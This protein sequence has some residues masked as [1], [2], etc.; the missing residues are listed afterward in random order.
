MRRKNIRA[1]LVT[2]EGDDSGEDKIA[3]LLHPATAESRVA[4]LTALLYANTHGTF[5]ERIACAV[6]RDPAHH[7]YRAELASR[8]GRECEG[9]F[10]CGGNPYLYARLVD[11]VTVET[12]ENGG[13]MLRWREIDA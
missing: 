4:H 7:P 8:N 12:G 10:I 3:L 2:W 6:E 5:T 11:Q 9:Q 1:W 13:E